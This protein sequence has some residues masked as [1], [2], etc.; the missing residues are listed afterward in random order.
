MEFQIV[1]RI[2]IATSFTLLM[3]LVP[4]AQTLNQTFE[5]PSAISMDAFSIFQRKYID[6]ELL[7]STG[8]TKV[9]IVATDGLSMKELSK[10]MVS[11]RA[12]PSMGGLYLIIGV[13]PASNVE[14]IASNPGILA[15][16][17]D[18]KIEYPCSTDILVTDSLGRENLF[19][20]PLR[21][22][23]LSFEDCALKG[24][25]ETTL[26][27][28]VDVIG[29]E[30]AWIELGVNGADV[31]IAI[32]DTGVDYGALSLGYWDTVARDGMGYP[33]VFD[34]DAMG[35]AITNTTVSATYMVGTRK[36]L[37]TSGIDPYVYFVLGPWLSMP[38]IIKLSDLIG[39]PWPADMEITGII[40]KS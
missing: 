24:K 18:R 14:F 9:L 38:V 28:V 19:F 20:L 35:L 31:T 11:C 40:S 15:I 27:E 16:L 32:V 36:Y 22:S 17:K 21:K 4:L 13:I 6:P 23:G 8:L 33:S 10:H 26:R 37:N 2:I 12:T 30:R 39:S 34:A 29:A 1:K 5:L 7:N 3:L 25:P